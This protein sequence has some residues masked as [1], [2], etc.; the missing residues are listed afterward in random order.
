MTF[1]EFFLKKKI[2]L[3]LFKKGKPDVFAE[4]VSHYEQMSEK[5]F[6][7][8]KKYW[9]NNLRIAFPLSEEKEQKL[10][11]AF[12]PITETIA[13][14]D[15]VEQS[16]GDEQTIIAKSPGFKPRFKSPVISDTKSIESDSPKSEISEVQLPKPTGFKPRFKAGVT[17]ST[18]KAQEEKLKEEKIESQ[19]EGQPS[20]P[21]GFK[22]RFKA[23]ITA[24]APKSE[25]DEKSE[26]IE[27]EI[28]TEDKSTVSKPSGF[29]P[30][31]KAG[32]TASI[33]KTE[34]EE[35]PEEVKSENSAEEQPEVTKP[36]GFKPRFK[37]TKKAD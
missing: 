16:V 29:K 33:P 11:D 26:A 32:V 4:F 15:T 1:E 22:P 28:S 37:T 35:K 34:N 3:D 30:R 6:D 2:D 5:S 20:K 18:P 25:G 14:K 27:K 31:F 10:K 24:S 19:E 21:A 17:A 23:G 12:K 9:F 7:H 8:T 13:K 36:V